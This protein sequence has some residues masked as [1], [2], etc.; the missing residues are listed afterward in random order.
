MSMRNTVIVLS[1]LLATSAL[2]TAAVA[3][4]AKKTTKAAPV[5]VASSQGLAGSWMVRARAIGVVPDESSTVTGATGTAD[6][7][8][9]IV[10]ELDFSYFFTNNIAAELILATSKHT[11]TLH[12]AGDTDLGSAWVLPPTLTVQYHFTDLSWAKPYVGAGVNYTMYYNEKA[13]ALSKPDLQDAFGLALQAGVDVP[14]DDRWS[15]NLDVKKIFV[16]ADATWNAGA[17][18]ADV[19]LNPWVIGTGVGY[20][21]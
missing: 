1:A 4:D 3:A 19:N 13:G 9:T 2:S 7:S 18:S 12:G 5:A 11:A 21:F 16:D 15:W 14:I 6:F 20:R 10:P 17:I 8:N